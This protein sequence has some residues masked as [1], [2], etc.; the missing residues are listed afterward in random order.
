MS[1]VEEINERLTAEL[2]SV[3]DEIIHKVSAIPGSTELS[4]A[5]LRQSDALIAAKELPSA[6]WDRYDLAVD[7]ANARLK[8]LQHA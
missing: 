7:L 2:H 4:N 8:E 5:F 6:N 3:C 1:T